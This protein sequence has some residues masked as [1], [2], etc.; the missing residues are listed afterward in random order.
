MKLHKHA[1]IMGGLFIFA[2]L[3]GSIIY[4]SVESWN[5]IDSIYFVVVTITTI[6]YGDISP[7][8]NLGKIFTMFFCFFGIAMAF[9]FLTFISSF[10]FEKKLK[11]RVASVREHIERKEELKEIKGKLRK[12]K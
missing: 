9:Y 5:Y 11:S 7:Q 3:F 2:I 12:R 8:T 10:M 6:G 4:H 1:V